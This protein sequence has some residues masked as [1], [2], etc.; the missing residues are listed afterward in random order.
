MGLLLAHLEQ[1][2]QHRVVVGPAHVE[3]AVQ[4]GSARRGAGGVGQERHRVGIVGADRDQPVGAGRVLLD[5]VGRQ[6]VEVG[7]VQRRR[8]PIVTDAPGEGLGEL[9][10]AAVEPAQPFSGRLVTVDAGAPEG[11]Q[12]VLEVA[13]RGGVE[14]VGVQRAELVVDGLVEV[15]VGAERLGLD[16]T[17]FGLL[18]HLGVGVHDGHQRADGEDVAQRD[19]NVVPQLQ[20]RLV[21]RRRTP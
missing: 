17:A 8:T 6:P 19:P 7:G 20:D 3:Q 13:P 21:A 18:D 5:V 1:L 12:R 4:H 10:L 16:V 14:G 11:Q 2:G 9:A 15:E